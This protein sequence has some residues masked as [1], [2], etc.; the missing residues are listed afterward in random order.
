MFFGKKNLAL[1]ICY[2]YNKFLINEAK[3]ISFY[4]N[5]IIINKKVRNYSIAEN[6]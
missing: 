5:L 1:Y 2:F 6:H 3:M 4:F